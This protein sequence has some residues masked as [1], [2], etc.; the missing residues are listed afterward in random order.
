LKILSK[1]ENKF[2][3]G[4]KKSLKFS[5]NLRRLEKL[6]EREGFEPPDT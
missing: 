1:A 2:L 3:K 6:A 4:N 5:K